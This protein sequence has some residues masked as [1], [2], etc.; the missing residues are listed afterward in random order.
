VNLREVKVDVQAQGA[1]VLDIEYRVGNAGWAPQYDL[2]AA[3]DG[4]SVD[5]SYR[6][7]VWQQSGEDW[8]DAEIALSTAQPQIGAQG[9]D[10][11][12]IKLRLFDPKD[13]RPAPTGRAEGKDLRGLGYLSDD[14]V[15]PATDMAAEAAP[16][17]FASIESQGLSVRFRLARKETIESR[18]APTNV[19]IG[20]AKLDATPEYFATPSL[21]TSVWLRGKTKNT[22][23]WT[24][25]PGRASVYFGADFIGHAQLAAVQ[26][27]EEFTLHL[28]PDPALTIE[29]KQIEDLKKAPGVFGS[30]T[31]QVEGW[32]IHIK[33]SGA[34][35]T[36]PDG[37]ATIFVREALPQSSD[38]R[39]KVE[40]SESTPQPSV[41]ARWKQE[42]DEQGLLT[43]VLSVPKNGEADIVWQSKV[44]FPEGTQV[45]R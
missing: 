42:R 44:S 28:G 36:G 17:P 4:K 11:Q 45:L 19:L 39:I 13:R 16:R 7:Q 20:Q 38:D 1:G 43:W 15:A 31:T 30:K 5:L 32:R 27:G 41:A 6:A 9:P 24:L 12:P 10:P 23:V 26:P 14:K 2:R 25:L 22:S 37:K 34:A 40:L 21:S 29:R 18:D 8:T 33:N 3:S 35:A